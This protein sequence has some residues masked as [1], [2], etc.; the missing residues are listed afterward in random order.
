[1]LSEITKSRLYTFKKIRRAYYSFWLLTVVFVISLFSEFVANEK[2]LYIYYQGSSYLP[3]FFFY[4]GT[5]FGQA[6]DSQADYIALKKDKNFLDQ[7]F[8]MWPLYPH[9]PLHSYFYTDKVPPNL[10]SIQHWLGTDRL[11]RDV[12]ARLLYGFRISILFSLCLIGFVTILG[13]LIGGLQ[14]YLGGWLDLSSQRL[15]E[16][17]SALPFLYVVI[18]VGSLYGRGFTMLIFVISLFNWIGLSYYMRA[19]FLRGK[20]QTYVL[21][22]R[23]IGLSGSR[24]FLSHILPNSLT[25]LITILPFVL[26]SGI[27]V[28]T[29]LDFLG[30]GLQPPTPSWGELLKQGLDVIREFPH[31][32]IVTTLV[33]FLTLLLA[34]LVGEGAREAF[35][36]RSSSSKK[37]V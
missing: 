8:V 35:D 16:I 6:Q 28:L 21:A 25:P 31:L 15:I 4:P 19:E 10:P 12:F 37:H 27:T 7:A 13:S 34:T 26:I 36:P 24:I 5:N 2:P 17:W 9:G 1:M 23:A 29:A 22:A 18:L 33:L 32:T 20:K 14:G 3:I 30:F 11:G